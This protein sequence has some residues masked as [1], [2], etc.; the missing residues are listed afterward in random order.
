V[1]REEARRGV[2]RADEAHHFYR[3]LGFDAD[4]K[5]AFVLRKV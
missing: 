4:S 5:Q 2:A 1:T 3:A